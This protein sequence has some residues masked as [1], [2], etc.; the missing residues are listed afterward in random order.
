[1]GAI[2][3]GRLPE[4][5]PVKIMIMLRPDLARALEDYSQ[6][7]AASYGKDE[8]LGELIPAILTAFL[9]SD[10]EFVRSRKGKGG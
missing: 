9:D 1:M 4:H 10:R 3:L 7:C 2:K 5:A 8:P 6:F